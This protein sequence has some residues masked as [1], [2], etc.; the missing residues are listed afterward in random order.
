MSTKTTMDENLNFILTFRTVNIHFVIILNWYNQS[1][2][3][4]NY[5]IFIFQVRDYLIY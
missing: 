2:I 1:K 3:K 4:K 5:S